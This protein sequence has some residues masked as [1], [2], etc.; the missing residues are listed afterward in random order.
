MWIC[1]KEYICAYLHN[2]HV[3]SGFHFLIFNIFIFPDT[4]AQT[5]VAKKKNPFFTVLRNQLE[6]IL[7]VLI[8]YLVKFY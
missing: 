8:G 4:K 6:N 5:F 1:I 3:Q 7:C 2:Q